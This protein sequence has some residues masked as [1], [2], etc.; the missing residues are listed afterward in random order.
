MVKLISITQS[1]RDDKK[2]QVK[3]E[4]DSGREKNIHI[5]AK[6]M[7]DFTK[8]KDEEAKERYIDRHKAR[9][10]WRLSGLLTAGFWAKHLLWNKPTLQASIRDTK[11]RF[12]L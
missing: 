9:E 5:G 10:D 8:T 1:P 12:N 3:L 6:G 4:T 2:L 7:D 11:E